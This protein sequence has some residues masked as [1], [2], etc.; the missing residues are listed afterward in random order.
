[1]KMLCIDGH[2]IMNRAYYGAKGLMTSDGRHSGAIYGFTNILMRE[3]IQYD[4]DAVVVAYDTP[5]KTFRHEMFDG[6][7]A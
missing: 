7:K 4:P 2:S 3:V 5:I 6:Y 1:M